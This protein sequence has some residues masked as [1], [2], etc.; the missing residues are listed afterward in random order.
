MRIPSSVPSY[1][2]IVACGRMLPVLALTAVVALSAHAGTITG[3]IQ[4]E[5]KA[6]VMKEIDMSSDPICSAKH[7]TPVRAEFLVLGDGQTMGNVFVRVV[8]GLEKKKYPTPAEAFILNQSGCKYTP[9]VFAVMR[10]Q[11]IEILNPDGTLHNI[12]SLPKL[13]KE[14]NKTMVK[15]MASITVKFPLPEGMF[16]IKCEVHPWMLAYC[17]VMS[18]PFFD[19]T[20]TDGAFKIEGLEPGDYVIEAWHERLGTQRAEITVGAGEDVQTRDFT[21]SRP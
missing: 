1:R 2:R 18:H 20:E 14:F 19:V 10:N 7:D 6:P 4:W 15:S 21:F 16:R 5:G 17:A 11:E 3:T 8:E 9:H 12:H 13:N